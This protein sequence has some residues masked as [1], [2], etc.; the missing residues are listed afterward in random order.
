MTAT[1]SSVASS[2]LSVDSC[3]VCVP[4][5]GEE[6]TSTVRRLGEVLL[7]L[8]GWEAHGGR[9]PEPLAGRAALES[10]GRLYRALAPAQA[11]PDRLEVRGAG[12]E[13]T[14]PPLWFAEVDPLDVEMMAETVASFRRALAP[15]QPRPV[16]DTEE[17]L[18]DA[19]SDHRRPGET[20]L[21]LVG[22]AARL[23]RLLEAGWDADVELVHNRLIQ[24]QVSEG[25]GGS[26]AIELSEAEEEAYQRIT[27]RVSAI[28]DG[29]PPSSRSGQESSVAMAELVEAE[30]EASA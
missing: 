3:V 30:Q 16:D 20:L 10:V 4:V 22:Q 14:Y 17:A 29:P 12:R 11:Q 6:L 7:T 1:T 25:T 28:W 15:D 13:R 5:L 27:E 24:D 9:L 2:H 8:D 21:T 19:L 23:S 18:G 26:E